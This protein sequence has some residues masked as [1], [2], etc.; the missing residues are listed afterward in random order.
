[1]G[2]SLLARTRSSVAYAA[3]LN[4]SQLS[5]NKE[6][7]FRAKLPVASS[8][9]AVVG[10]A[11]IGGTPSRCQ[12]RFRSLSSFLRQFLPSLRRRSDTIPFARVPAPSSA[13][14]IGQWEPAAAVTLSSG[15][16]N[17]SEAPRRDASRR[18]FNICL[19]YRVTCEGARRAT[20]RTLG[21]RMRMAPFQPPTTLQARCGEGQGDKSDCFKCPGGQA[22]ATNALCGPHYGPILVGCLACMRGA[23]SCPQRR[24]LCRAN[25]GDCVQRW[26]R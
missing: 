19:L 6:A 4:S 1:M 12:Q 20:G 9:A 3:L 14:G 23:S 13:A 17:P 11:Y 22:G 18:A 26:L 21:G 5:R 7:I 8:V 15:S 10:E 25:T 24:C 16:A 2:L